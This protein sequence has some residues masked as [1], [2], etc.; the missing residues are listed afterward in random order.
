MQKIYEYYPESEKFQVDTFEKLLCNLQYL[1]PNEISLVEKAY[2]KAEKL[3]RD[4]KPRVATGKPYITHP[5]SVTNLLAS[6]RANYKIICAAL[7]H[8][9]VEDTDYTVREVEEGFGKDIAEIVDTV[10]K[11]STA[12]D[13]IT[14]KDQAR[15]ATH[16]KI[17]ESVN[18]YGINGIYGIMVKIADRIDNIQSLDGFREDK[19][20]RI[21]SETLHIYVPLARISGIYDA[22]DFLE[23]ASLMNMNPEQFDKFYKLRKDIVDASDVLCNEF[24]ELAADI[25]TEKNISFKFESKVKNLYGIYKQI[26]ERGKK[27]EQINDIIGMKFIVPTKDDCYTTLGVVHECGVPEKGY[28]DDYIANPK[29]NGYMS[30]NTLVRYKN[31]RMQARIRSEKMQRCNR[32][33]LLNDDNPSADKIITDIQ[34]NVS[35][36]NS[37]NPNDKEFILEAEKNILR[38]IITVLSP[39]GKRVRLHDGD[40]ALDYALKVN[41]VSNQNEIDRIYVNGRK[42]DNFNEALCDEDLVYILRKEN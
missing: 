26:V 25:L 10:T 42:L 31:S 32:L 18:K 12:K 41:L 9:T 37:N 40:T 35:Q 16:R 2:E 22:K 21:A 13:G 38:P 28:F 11:I 20:I 14:D 17:L 8:D 23:N 33:G 39:T 4:S 24:C 7:L 34:R 27:L 36:I 29:P 19:K 5:L 15:D 3:H 6:Y 1:T 30:L